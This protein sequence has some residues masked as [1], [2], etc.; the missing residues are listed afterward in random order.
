MPRR[1]ASDPR[2]TP[3][4][5]RSRDTYDTVL[6]ATARILE[7]KGL[8]AA[9]TNAIAARAGISV[10]SLYQYFPGKTAIFAELIRRH[11]AATAEGLASLVAATAGQDLAAR[12]RALVRAAVAQQFAR[13][14]LARILDYLEATLGADEALAAADDRIVGSI[15]ALL[16]AHADQ[17]ARAPT[18]VVARDILWIA[19]G[20]I[21][22]ASLAGDSDGA[23]VEPRVV[24]ALLGYLGVDDD[25]DRAGEVIGPDRRRRLGSD[26][27]RS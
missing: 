1:R 8:E 4:Q 12:L 22:G 6:D 7:T 2:K 27:S 21:D 23:A 25:A 20:M 11:D 26:R 19:K 3:L 5:A 10:G 15:E 16:R 18:P 17:L 13:P 9:N 14:R 24:A